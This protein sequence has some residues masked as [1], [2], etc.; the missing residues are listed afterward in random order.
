M[1][2]Q[3]KG[4]VEFAFIRVNELS[5]AQNL[6]DHKDRKQVYITFQ[7]THDIPEESLNEILQEAILLDE[8]TPYQSKRQNK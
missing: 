6:L 8:T 4:S 5:N 7:N 2:P 1:N 3:K